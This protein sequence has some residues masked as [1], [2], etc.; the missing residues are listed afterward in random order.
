[1]QNISTSTLKGTIIYGDEFET[2]DGYITIEDGIIKDIE[3]SNISSETIIS[4]CFINAHTHIGD[5]VVKDPPYMPLKELVMP[6]NGFKH[7]VL[8][9]TKT[10]LLISAMNSSIKDMI[11]TGTCGFAD[12]RENGIS[13]VRALRKAVEGCNIETK[14]FGRPVKDETDYL[15]ISDGT[16]LS[17]TNDLDINLI[18]KIVE[19]TKKKDKKFAIHAGE[20]DES[21][22][23][24]AIELEPDFIV[25]F[26]HAKKKYIKQVSDSNIPVIV[27]V[28][29]NFFTHCGIPPIK[30]ML[31]QDIL[32]AAGTDNVMINSTNMFSEMEFLS[33]TAL[34]NDRQVFKLSTLNGAKI[35]GIDKELGSIKKGKKAK[36]MV[37]TKKSNNMKHTKNIISSLV[38]R[39]RV[40]DI[41]KI[42]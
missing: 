23:S 31:E 35:L 12:F 13:G 28:R 34:F 20:R 38:R 9:N 39:A 27:C 14:I 37:I 10:S 17:S 22:I 41:I 18:K 7:R 15:D 21:D 40:D 11:H 5:S 32:V 25:H 8:K 2:I 3:E 36:L 29:S 30:E 19:D 16:G 24:D 42:I 1:M 26:T 6:P 4:P 33:K